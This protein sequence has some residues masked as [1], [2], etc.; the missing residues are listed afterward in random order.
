[1][2]QEADAE[3]GIIECHQRTGTMVDIIDTEVDIVMQQ[4]EGN[5]QIDHSS[6]YQH[7]SV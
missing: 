3:D 5:Q 2:K 6:Q 1:M 4:G 7:S